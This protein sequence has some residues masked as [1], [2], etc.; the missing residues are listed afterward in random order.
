M[1]NSRKMLVMSERKLRDI[2]SAWFMGDCKPKI[3]ENFGIKHYQVSKILKGYDINARFRPGVAMLSPYKPKS[4]EYLR[5]E[6]FL[7]NLSID[8][9]LKLA[10]AGIISDGQLKYETKNNRYNDDEG[11]FDYVLTNDIGANHY[12]VF[13][14]DYSD[15]DWD[16]LTW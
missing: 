4:A 2:I 8:Q 6:A 15:T 12:H 13:D 1:M 16:G 10:D 14:S 5:M 9:M 3:A 11:F 7:K